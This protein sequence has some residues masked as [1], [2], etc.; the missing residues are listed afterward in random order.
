MPVRNSLVVQLRFTDRKEVI[1]IVTFIWVTCSA[2]HYTNTWYSDYLPMSDM[3]SYDNTGKP[4]NVSRIL[5]PNLTLD[6]EA[7]KAY[8]PLFLSTTFAI[9]YGLNFAATIGLIVHTGLYHGKDLWK[10]LRHVRAEPKDI[11][12]R[13]VEK[14]PPVPI[15]WYFILGA[16]MITLGFITV[17]KYDTQ[18]PAWGYV[19][20]IAIAL[21]FL[22]RVVK[23]N[24]SIRSANQACRYPWD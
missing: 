7:Y 15:W 4:Y 18:L 3:N 5:T 12:V 20:A 6:L 24:G 1:G 10:R 9:F 17:C 14:Y 13:L 8:S 16:I 21:F 11:H 2:V 23:R 19:L 22:V